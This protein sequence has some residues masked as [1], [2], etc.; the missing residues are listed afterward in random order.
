VVAVAKVADCGMPKRISVPSLAAPTAVRSL[1]GHLEPD[2]DRQAADEQDC[3]HACDD[4][5]L[6]DVSDHPAECP[7]S[8]NGMSSSR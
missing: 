7:G 2:V 8:E 1:V 5:A 3:H 4:Q 6:P